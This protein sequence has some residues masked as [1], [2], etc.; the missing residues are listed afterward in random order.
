MGSGRKPHFGIDISTSLLKQIV[1]N[2]VAQ[3]FSCGFSYEETDD[4][5]KQIVQ[6][7]LTNLAV[8]DAIALRGDESTAWI[9]P[10]FSMNAIPATITPMFNTSTGAV[11]L[12]RAVARTFLLITLNLRTFSFDELRVEKT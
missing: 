2:Q 4:K 9:H 1:A 3:R 10:R 12:P 11:T 6:R 8:T 7:F 5:T